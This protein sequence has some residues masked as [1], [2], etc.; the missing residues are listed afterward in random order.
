M[1][2]WQD[3]PIPTS[4]T[5]LNPATA[6]VAVLMFRNVLGY[7]GE[8]HHPYPDTLAE[9]IIVH[10]LNEPQ[11]QDELFCQVPF[12]A[13]PSSIILVVALCVGGSLEG[14][15]DVWWSWNL[16]L[17]RSRVVVVNS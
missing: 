11:M 10:G 6:K 16:W 7:C 2:L 14:W 5:S 4:L 13:R 8:A 15:M 17:A 1:L 9:D 12:A 3:W